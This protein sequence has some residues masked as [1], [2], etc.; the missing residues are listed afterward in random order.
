MN[1]RRMDRNAAIAPETCGAAMLVP[2]SSTYA[3]TT[4][5]PTGS[6]IFATFD[7][8]AQDVMRSPGATRSGFRRPCPVGPFDEKND[9]PYVCG[10]SRCV[11]PT[12]IANAALPGS[13]IVF[14]RPTIVLRCEALT[15]PYP[16]L[17]AATTTTT[18]LRTRRST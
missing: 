13:L 1:S 18:P 15:L 6:F 11:E 7:R 14:D 3:P 12:V 10:E 17:P 4:P 16:V 8:D 9:T 2:L 5:S